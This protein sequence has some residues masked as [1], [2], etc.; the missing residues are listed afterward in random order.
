[1]S[2]EKKES[3]KNLILGILNKAKETPKVKL[4]KL[5]L[6][7]EIEHFRRTKKSITGLYF[8]RLKKGPVIA[9]FD[10]ILEEGEGKFWEK[11]TTPIH[12]LEEGRTKVQYSYVLKQKPSLPEE[13][14]KTIEGV[15]HKYGKKTGTQLSLLAHSLPAWKY[16]EPNE[17]IYLAELAVKDEEE[18]FALSDL[19]EDIEEIDED[20]ALAQ[21]IPSSLR[22][23]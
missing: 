2:T 7:T 10:E 4:A 5:V 19:V 3:L 17:P 12:I 1:M 13:A 8:V 18:Y 9:F 11:R 22:K 21:K 15:V 20:D 23:T 16:S 6:F 14:N